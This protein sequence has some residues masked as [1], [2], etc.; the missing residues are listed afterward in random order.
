MAGSAGSKGSTVTSGSAGAAASI[1]LTGDAGWEIGVS[2]TLAHPPGAVWDFITG[3]EG[4]SCWLGDGVDLHD[5]DRGQSFETADGTVG[6]VRSHRP[7]DRIRITWR[8][9]GWDH[10]T[11][12]QVAVSPARGASERAVLRFHQ[13]RLA[14]PEERE[15][16]R[17]HWRAVME[18]VVA[19]LD[20]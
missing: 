7:G 20:G 15:R 18:S 1:G 19:A 12:V 3:P 14:G 2:K 11:T 10:D 13:E 4:L 16:Q 5:A 6:E 17:A 8:P 9:P